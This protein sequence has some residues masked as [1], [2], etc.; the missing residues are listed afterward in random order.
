MISIFS[1]FVNKNIPLGFGRALQSLGVNG[2]HVRA[3]V[4]NAV[5]IAPLVVVP[6]D[7]LDEV[8]VESDAGLSVED[9][10]GGAKGWM[11]SGKEGKGE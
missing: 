11:S 3:E 1:Q 4:D 2:V 10:A 9:A 5:G 8:V 7:E 6:G